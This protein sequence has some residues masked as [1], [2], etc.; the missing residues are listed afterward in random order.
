MKERRVVAHHVWGAVNRQ[1]LEE[2]IAPTRAQA[3]VVVEKAPDHSVT[4][5]RFT[6]VPV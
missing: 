2:C 6:G 4:K 1:N 3:S 5:V